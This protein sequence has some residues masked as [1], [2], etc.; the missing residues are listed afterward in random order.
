MNAASTHVNRR[1][2]LK[3]GAAGATGLVIGFYLPSPREALA[4]LAP[5]VK[6]DFAPNAWIRIVPNNLVTIIVARSEMGQGVM[7][8]LPMLVAEE[9]ECDWK[10][11]HAEFAPADKAYINPIIGAQGTGGSTS[12]RGSYTP[13]LQAGAAAREMLIAAAAEKWKVDKSACRAENGFVINKS[14]KA[15]LS[16]G[17]LAS[18]ASK[19]PVPADVPL[20]DPKQYHL[21][22]KATKRLDTP[23]KVD[24]RAGFGI[25]VRMPGLLYGSVARCP[26]FGGKVAS[27]DDSKAKAVPGVRNVVQISSGVAAIGDSTWSAMEGRRALDIKWDEGPTASVS[28]ASIRQLFEQRAGE[29]GAIARK[30]G[31]GEA[32]LASAARKIEAVYE[33]PFL[34]HAT[35]EPMNCTAHVRADGCDVWAPT[36]FQT[37]AQNAAVKVTGLK[38]EEVRIHTTFLGG[39]FG[40]RAEPDYVLDAVECSKAVNAPVKVTWSREDDIQHDYYRPAA[41]SRFTAGL[42][43]DGWPVALTA[44]LVCTSIFARV[45]PAQ[46]KNGVDR[47]SVEGVN[48]LAY[49]IPNIQVECNLTDTGVPVG[50]WRSVGHSQNCFFAESFF[51]EIAAATKKDPYEL[52]RRYLGK[53]QRHLKVL[54][55][56]ASRAGWGTP[57]P[58]GRG[59]GIAVMTGYGSYIAQ[60]AEVSVEKGKVRVHR[61][62]CAVDCGRVVNPDTIVAQMQSGSVYGLT[63]AL[64]GEITIDHGRVQQNNFNDYPMM[65]INEMPVVE[66]YIVPSEEEATGVGEPSTGTI[67]PAVCNAIFAATGKRIRRLPIRP[68][69]LA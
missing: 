9:L 34:A 32:G 33:A 61:V 24:G 66:V 57:L 1:G 23:D 41:Y 65:R 38:P 36:Q 27:V 20:K 6:G 16:Y 5:V 51:D 31:E 50:F 42:D 21:V 11:V 10:N 35:M 30:D 2:F 53:A 46:V 62:V 44:R 4:E 40:R 68:E 59:R 43:A 54:D 39:G 13:M 26:V 18:A 29:P 48:D 58:E 28:S 49:A 19:Q 25:D 7:T 52:R 22:G 3:A 56:A 47:V 55:V 67:A 64:Y 69:D 60:V 17:S 45:F 12:V 63:A 37:F 8:A 15:R 14:T